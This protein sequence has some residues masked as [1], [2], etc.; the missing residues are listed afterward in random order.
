MPATMPFNDAQRQAFAAFADVLI[1]AY[2]R[3]PAASTV[4]VAGDMLDEVLRLRPDIHAAFGRGLDSLGGADPSSAANELMAGDP[5]A[6]NA[7][8]LAA[9]A[10]YYMT[11]A[12]RECLG[13]PGQ[14]SLVYDAHATPDYM[15]NGLLERVVRRGPV[16]RATPMSAPK[17][18]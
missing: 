18:V 14:E 5:E 9:S 13:Y 17:A 2:G 10:G 6:F 16:Y 15:T 11:E 7:L 1:P 3:M 4:G 8:S 12:V